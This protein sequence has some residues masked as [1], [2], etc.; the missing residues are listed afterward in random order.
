MMSIGSPD[1]VIRQVVSIGS[2]DPVILVGSAAILLLLVLLG[3]AAVAHLH[4][5]RMEKRRLRS[6]K[7]WV[8]SQEPPVRAETLPEREADHLSGLPGEVHYRLRKGMLD[9]SATTSLR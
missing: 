2:L 4:D 6:L 1:P 9:S 7:K 5:R 8:N 3:V